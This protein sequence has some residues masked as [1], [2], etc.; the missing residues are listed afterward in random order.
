MDIPG[1]SKNYY[2]EDKV[3]ELNLTPK[4]DDSVDFLIRDTSTELPDPSILFNIN[5]FKDPEAENIVIQSRVSDGEDT[6]H[7]IQFLLKNKTEQT[8]YF[9]KTDDPYNKLKISVEEGEVVI[10]SNL[11]SDPDNTILNLEDLY[12]VTVIVSHEG[13]VYEKILSQIRK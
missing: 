4:D 11:N 8:L 6:I 3:F 12:E 10:I 2:N 7:R 9:Y 1:Y 13:R 5:D